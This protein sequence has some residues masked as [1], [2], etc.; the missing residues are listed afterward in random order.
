MRGNGDRSPVVDFPVLA[1]RYTRSKLP[2]DHSLLLPQNARYHNSPKNGCKEAVGV[3]IDSQ[4][5]GA[6]KLAQASYLKANMTRFTVAFVLE[7]GARVIPPARVFI[8]CPGSCYGDLRSRLDCI[9][10]QL[11]CGCMTNTQSWGEGMSGV[12]HKPEGVVTI[13]WSNRRPV[14]G[15]KKNVA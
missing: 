13:P 4:R 15:S 12:C 10:P 6:P 8:R 11:I 14:A 1:G 3:A 9:S 2:Y 7:L 5:A